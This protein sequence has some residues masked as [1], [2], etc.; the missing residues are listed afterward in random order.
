M[1]IKNYSKK[2]DMV[3]IVKN[4]MTKLTILTKPFASKG[5]RGFIDDHV[6]TKLTNLINKMVK[7]VNSW[8]IYNRLKPF[9]TLHLVKMVKMAGYKNKIVEK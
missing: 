2:Y 1:Q 6:L 8:P 7:M 9:T 5:Y 3:F 4:S